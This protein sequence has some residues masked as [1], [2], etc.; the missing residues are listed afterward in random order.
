[1][2]L[3]SGCNNLLV[4]VESQRLPQ[5]FHNLSVIARSDFYVLT[6]TLR[7]SKAEMVTFLD[8]ELPTSNRS[9]DMLGASQFNGNCLDNS[10]LTPILF[11]S[12]I[13]SKGSN[14]GS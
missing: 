3:T 8:S 10:R 2:F 12:D 4:V 13:A 5:A 1:M 14:A 11:W 9:T 6:L 7:S